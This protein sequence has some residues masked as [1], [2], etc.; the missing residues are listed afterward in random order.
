LAHEFPSPELQL[1]RKSTPDTFIMD[2]RA[3]P[4]VSPADLIMKGIAGGK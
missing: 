4:K 3:S 1:F 2:A